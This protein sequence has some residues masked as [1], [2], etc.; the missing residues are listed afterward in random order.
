MRAR[1][2]AYVRHLRRFLLDTWHPDT[3]PERLEFDPGFEWLGLE[4]VDSVAGGPLDSTG[5]V[6]FRARFARGGEHLE[7]HERSTFERLGGKWVYV[8][9]H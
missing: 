9:G 5:I 3:R 8:A 7:L 4:V 2:S 1:Y 6:E